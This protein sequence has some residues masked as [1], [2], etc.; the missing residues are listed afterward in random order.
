MSSASDRQRDLRL[1]AEQCEAGTN[2]RAFVLGY[3]LE[4]IGETLWQ[5]AIRAA[6]RELLP[7]EPLWDGTAG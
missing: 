3:V 1:L 7:Q 5:E 4:S 2:V 6:E